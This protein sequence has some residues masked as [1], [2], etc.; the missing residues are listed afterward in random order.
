MNKIVS[1]TSVTKKNYKL[2][3]QFKQDEQIIGLRTVI[4]AMTNSYPELSK[5]Y[6]TPEYF[7]PEWYV[8]GCYP[9]D[10]YIIDPESI[11]LF[12]LPK[13]TQPWTEWKDAKGPLKSIQIFSRFVRFNYIYQ[14]YCNNNYMKYRIFHYNY[15][16]SQ[17]VAYITEINVY[18]NEYKQFKVLHPGKIIQMPYINAVLLEKALKTKNVFEYLCYVTINNRLLR[19]INIVKS[20]IINE[21]LKAVIKHYQ[22]KPAKTFKVWENI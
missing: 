19:K 1:I 16:K 22:L 9:K 7:K 6:K 15:I 4:Q 2:L 21:N 13:N 20:P 10:P 17:D 8:L 12:N 5:E 18:T 14:I 11:K 3:L